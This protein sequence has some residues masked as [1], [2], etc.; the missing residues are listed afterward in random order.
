MCGNVVVSEQK[1]K[2]LKWEGKEQWEMERIRKTKQKINKQK[3]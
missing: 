2:I 3:S 1:N